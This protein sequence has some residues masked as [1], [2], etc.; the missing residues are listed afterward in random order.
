VSILL[1]NNDGTVGM[2]SLIVVGSSPGSLVV[3]DFNEDNHLDI[4]VGVR[5]GAG[6]FVMLLLGVGNGSFTQGESYFTTGPGPTGLVAADV[7]NDDNLDLVMVT[8][9]GDS[10]QTILGNGDGTFVQPQKFS[11][12]GSFPTGVA[13]GNFDRDDV[14]DVVSSSNANAGVTVLRGQGDGG[15]GDFVAIGSH[16]AGG[17]ACPVVL[18]HDFD[19]DGVLDLVV[20]NGGAHTFSILFGQVYD[21]GGPPNGSFGPP[22]PFTPG[23]Y[24]GSLALGDYN[25]DGRTDVAATRNNN[26]ITVFVAGDMGTDAGFRFQGNYLVGNFALSIAAGDFN[27]DGKMDLVTA[28][29]DDSTVSILI[30]NR[31]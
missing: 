10:L 4:A 28:N 24:V 11:N 7:N 25:L 26:R 22:K 2:P 23:G 18:T 29:F 16:P 20:A 31:Q 8:N 5:P 6:G 15:T 9:D 21:M 3:A 1:G 27:S 30:N 14:R 13:V 17:S 12:T 19:E